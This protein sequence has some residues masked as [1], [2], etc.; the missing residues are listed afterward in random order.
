MTTGGGGMIVSQSQEILDKIKYYSTQAKDDS[1]NFVHNE[2]GYNYRMTNIQAA[3][4]IAQ[5][6]N[7]EDFIKTKSDNYWLYKNTLDK[8]AG[9]EILDFRN[10]IRSNYWFYSL[11]LKNREET[12]HK[13]I[14]FLKSSNIQARPI[15]GL[16]SKQKPY[17][18]NKSY[19]IEKAY[20]YYERVV[21]IPCSTNLSFDD[22][23]SVISVLKKKLGGTN[24]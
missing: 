5:L 16:I 17:S 15:W 1:V 13:I 8:V 10:G 19:K 11:L 12:P 4:G 24:G 3:V 23:N 21:N 7:L 18:H 22:V 20:Y 9:L 2:I 6:E 14:T